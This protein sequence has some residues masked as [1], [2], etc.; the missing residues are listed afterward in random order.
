MTDYFTAISEDGVRFKLKNNGTWEPDTT[1]VSDEL[2]RF[3]SSDWGDSIAKIKAVEGQDPIH[4]TDD[5][6]AYKT[7]VGGFPAD[8][9]FHFVNGLF[10]MS[11]Y[12]FAQEHADNNRFLSDLETLQSLLTTKYG[13]PLKVNDVWLNDLYED[14]Y[15][16]R[17][18]AV[19]IGHH[20]IFVSWEDEGSIL[21]LQLTGDNHQI[22]LNLI[23]Q[24][25]RLKVL[26]DAADEREKLVGL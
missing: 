5:F 4:E 23:Y 1:L 20:V 13:K 15:A 2:I 24:S 7:S 17:G 21:R 12:S 3:R 8:M 22:K 18:L 26:A 9:Y 6:L 16:E 25:K 19:A 10:Y 14:D 11:I